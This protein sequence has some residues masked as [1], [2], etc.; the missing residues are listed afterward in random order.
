MNLDKY[1][2]IG[3]QWMWNILIPLNLSIFQ[4]KFT[5]NKNIVKNFYRIQANES[6]ICA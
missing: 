6:I 5:G 2:S 3:T 4:T 1:R